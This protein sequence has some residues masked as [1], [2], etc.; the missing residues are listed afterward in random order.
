[1]YDL[2][3]H[4]LLELKECYVGEALAKMHAALHLAH[5]Q[6]EELKGFVRQA[7]ATHDHHIH[8]IERLLVLE[9]VVEEE[10]P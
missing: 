10:E 9:G 4:E 1:V 5:C 8:Q 2:S 3:P 7:M 6:D